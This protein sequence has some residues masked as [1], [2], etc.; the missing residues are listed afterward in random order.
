M[1]ID[2]SRYYDDNYEI[3]NGMKVRV[4]KIEGPYAHM[5]PDRNNDASKKDKKENNNFLN[6]IRN[7]FTN[8]K[9]A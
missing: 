3:I 9:E 1:D 5:L 8:K 6:K 4:I 7:G 2:V